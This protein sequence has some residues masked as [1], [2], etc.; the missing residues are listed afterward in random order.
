MDIYRAAERAMAMDESVWRRHANPLSVYTRMAIGPA[1]ALAIFA[2]DWIGGWFLLPVALLVA[3]TWLNPRAFPAPENYDNW[4]S[5]GVLGE[6]W[7]LARR[8]VDLPR[9]HMRAMTLLTALSLLGFI[10]LGWG[11]WALDPG[12]T[13]AGTL[14]MIGPKI[15]F[16]DRC[17]WL[18]ADMTGHVRGTGLTEPLLPPEGDRP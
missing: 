1:L 18:F 12:W 2:R 9:H 15:V 3:W 5:L 16:I 14:L 4:A 11:L 13:F 10:P 8:N 7:F 6:R 17:V